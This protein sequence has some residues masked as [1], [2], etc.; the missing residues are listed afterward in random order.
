MKRFLSFCLFQ[1]PALLWA[2][3]IYYASSIPGARLPRIV[4]ALNDKVLHTG[5]FF[6][7]G[8]FLAR[9][10]TPRSSKSGE[11][12]RIFAFRLIVA[13]I[14]V[15]L[16]GALDEMHQA[17][18]PG[19]TVDIKDAAADAIGGILAAL[20]AWFWHRRRSASSP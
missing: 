1:G 12:S 14:L 9:A 8:L 20:L 16:Y 10:L 13:T 3:V 4:I 15:A 6:V 7:L 11:N 17:F 5:T 2:G 18:V 19:R